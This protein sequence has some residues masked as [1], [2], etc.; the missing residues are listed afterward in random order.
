LTE[1][2]VAESARKILAAKYDLG[3]VKERITSLDAIDQIV[4]S[5][6][7]S[8]LAREIA[9]HAVTLVRDE[10]KLVPLSSAN[11]GARIFNLAIT[12]GDDRLLV[13]N[14]FVAAMTRAGR[15]I[16][17]V[18]LDD[19]SSNDDVQK[20]L[21]RAKAADIVIASL[22]G[23]VR[24]G[25]IRSVGLPDPGARALTALIGEQKPIIAISFGNPYLLMSFPGLRTYLVA[26]GDMPSLQQAAAR[27][28][29]GASDITGTL[30][31][32]LPGL[33]ARGIGV[34]L[35]RNR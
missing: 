14:T 3:L 25:E 33:Y 8:E 9:E 27:A 28:L 29:L 6:E 20:V 7:A 12:N 11:P 10:D 22:Y 23:R 17:T 35:V 4:S 26:Y 31:I 1:K 2:R 32:S 24:S 13:A 21:E 18:V 34:Q 15:K 16:E 30:P 5:R 19:R